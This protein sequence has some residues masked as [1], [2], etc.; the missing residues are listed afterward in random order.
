MFSAITKSMFGES[1]VTHL[2]ASFEQISNLWHEKEISLSPESDRV[3]VRSKNNLQIL[4]RLVS[5]R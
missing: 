3:L 2:A 1:S 4:V 5:K